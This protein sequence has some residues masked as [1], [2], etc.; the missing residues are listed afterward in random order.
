[1]EK[2]DVVW[3]RSTR[4]KR[5]VRAIL[6]F[7]VYIYYTILSVK[8][9]TIS[10]TILLLYKFSSKNPVTDKRSI[11]SWYTGEYVIRT[12]NL[13]DIDIQKAAISLKQGARYSTLTINADTL[14]MKHQP[15]AELL[16]R[17]RRGCG[18]LHISISSAQQRRYCRCAAETRSRTRPR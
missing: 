7:I 15:F 5:T 8:S 12:Q 11:Y 17:W 1:M 2:I 4:Y 3:L 10:F 18:Y 14:R 13:P 9:R 6:S 16:A